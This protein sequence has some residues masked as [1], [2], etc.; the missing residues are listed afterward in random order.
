[1]DLDIIFQICH[2][3]GKSEWVCFCSGFTK[4]AIE[5]AHTPNR[6]PW[7]DN[8]PSFLRQIFQD[9]GSRVS[10][11]LTR[12]WDKET[13][14]S[15]RK[16]SACLKHEAVVFVCRA[17]FH[18][19]RPAGP[20]WPWGQDAMW[21]GLWSW[22]SPLKVWCWEAV[23]QRTPWE[24]QRFSPSSHLLRQPTPPS[25]PLIIRTCVSY[26][27]S[28]VPWEHPKSWCPLRTFV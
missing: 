1:M 7:K 26:C 17:P 13:Q 11:V 14:G 6:G 24:G 3:Q 25:P 21:P 8:I 15:F 28:L 20:E 18:N 5:L 19:E 22:K 27:S 4:R 23:M 10:C 16:N 2:F 9:W 12:G